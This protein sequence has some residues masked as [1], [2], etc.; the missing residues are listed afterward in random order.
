LL[1]AVPRLTGA[2]SATTPASPPGA[3]SASPA[4]GNS[5]V[6]PPKTSSRIRFVRAKDASD[7]SRTNSPAAATLDPVSFGP[8][9]RLH[10]DSV[11]RIVYVKDPT[12]RASRE[13]MLAGKYALAEFRANLSRLEPYVEVRSDLSDF[14]NRRGAFGNTVESVVGVK[15]ETF[16]GAVLSTEVGASHSR[17]EFDHAVAG[18]D[19][20]ESGAGALLRAR[21]EMP[22]FGSRRLQDRIIAQAFQDSTARKAQ[23]DYLKSFRA[24]VENALSYYN[25]VVFWQRSLESYEKW[26]AALDLLLRDA[27][28]RESDRQR[29]ET[30]RAAVESNWNH[31]RSRQEDNIGTFLAYLGGIPE[32]DVEIEIPNYRLSPFVEQSRQDQGLRALIERAR[33]NNPA[34]RILNDAIKNARLQHE[35]AVRGRYDVTMFLEGTTFPLGS[36]AFDDRYEGWMIGGGINVRLNDRRARNATRLRSE[37]QIRQFEAEM[38]A[39]EIGIQQKIV[40]NTTT[41]LSNDENRNQLLAAA[42]RMAAAFETRRAEYFAGTI[43]IDQL[44]TARADIAANEGALNTNLQLTAEREALLALAIGQ[45]YEMVGLKIGSDTTAL[46]PAA[47]SALKAEPRNPGRSGE[48]P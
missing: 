31:V 28:V 3:A 42:A 24:Q 8:P 11:V 19:S 15:K 23:L 6:A 1:L 41:I 20:V 17:F 21:L 35:Q 34:F 47:D 5:T 13:E 22:F 26:M 33:V 46:S 36:E 18:G 45:V 30:T 10:F 43:N 44:L 2:D 25:Q 16:G 9:Y 48:T 4:S 39:E 27:R 14:P 32:G 29:I 12:V 40:S 7:R 37:A 38:E